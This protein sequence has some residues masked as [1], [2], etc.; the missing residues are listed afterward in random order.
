MARLLQRWLPVVVWAAIIL[1][2]ANDEFSD[3]QTQGWLTRLFGAVPPLLNMVLRKGGHIVAYGILALLAWRAHRTLFIALFV[4]VA[5]AVTD[6]TL[7]ALTVSRG[8]SPFDVLLDTCGA[9]LALL[10]LPAARR[11]ISGSEER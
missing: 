3:E 4:V 2:A 1:S 6:E 11:Q 7:Q 5:V 9:L 8:G 10:C